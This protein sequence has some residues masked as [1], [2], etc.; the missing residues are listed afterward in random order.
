MNDEEQLRHIA[1]MNRR[2]S[3][4]EAYASC[5]KLFPRHK[6]VPEFLIQM[7]VAAVG[8]GRNDKAKTLAER[9]LRHRPDAGSA[10]NILG[11][12]A[13]RGRDYA[14]ALSHFH[15]FVACAP[16]N[17]E[18][19]MNAAEAFNRAKRAEDAAQHLQRACELAPDQPAA[20]YAYATTLRSLGRND[21]ASRHLRRA[22]ELNPTYAGA[23]KLLAD[24]GQLTA[25]ADLDGL[26]QALERL[27]GQNGEQAKIHAALAL[28]AEREEDFARA[29]E[30]FDRANALVRAGLD[31]DVSEDEAL[32]KNTAEV[33]GAELS[34][35]LAG[36]GGDRGRMIFIVGM[37][38]SGTTLV[39]QIL[40]GHSQVHAGGELSFFEDALAVH[41][42]KGRHAYPLAAK[43]WQGRDLRA[44]ARYYL[45]QLEVLEPAAPWVT[46]K[47]PG[48]F[49]Y[50][51]AIR[52]VFPEARIIH[53][54]RDPIDTCLSNYRQVFT[55]RQ[56]F[57][58][59][60]TDLTRYYNAYRGLMEHW[61]A[62]LGDAILDVSYEH[63]VQNAEEDVRK[64]FAHCGLDWEAACLD[65]KKRRHAVYTAS[66]TQVREGIHA[67]NVERWRKYE[68]FIQLLLKGLQEE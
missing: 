34:R 67:R 62:L 31:Y 25:E 10:H 37:P 22:L 46:D 55:S 38:R 66:A 39:E 14:T 35:R 36:Q 49:L 12:V 20:H 42:V 8:C 28:L 50:L 52:A 45:D 59:D 6:D 51:G 58:Y 41:G 9:L 65:V 27:D 17:V 47:M 26:Q 1:A 30:H 53:C 24:L 11:V 18:A 54:M 15:D 16:G 40:A 29:F 23:W 7:A 21:E 33:F 57:S 13:L 60:L 44:M 64:I 43:H 32:M 68:A 2:G 61:R 19:H 4:A 48:N 63:L 3:F 56:D 5:R